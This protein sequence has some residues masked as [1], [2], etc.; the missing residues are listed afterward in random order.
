M[1][2]VDR[3]LLREIFFP[4]AVG[5]LAILQL[6]VILQ[7]LQLNQVVFGSAVTLVDLGRV[8]LALAPHFLVTAVPLAYMLGVQLG[9]GRLAGDQELLA[10]GAAGVHPLRLYRVPVAIGLVLAAGVFAL[11]RWAEPWGLQQ[12]NAVL[13]EVIKR[14][15]QSG[16]TPGVFNDALP[17]FTVYVGGEEKGAWKGVLIED[18][19]GDGAP[20]LALAESGRIEDVGGEA[21]ALR[22]YRGELHRNEP[23][24]ETV[25]RFAEGSFLVGVQ[26]PV[27]HQNRFNNNYG[28]LT[29]AQLRARILD[30]EREGNQ[31]E[32]AR[33]RVELARRWAAPLAV[34]FFALLAVP[35]AV[36]ARGA[37]GSAYLI[38]LGVFV[39]FYALSRLALAMAEGGLNAWL[40]GFLP[41]AAIGTL[42]IVYTRELVRRGVGKPR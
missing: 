37:R 24:G 13:N 28:Q 15:L 4:L 22:L 17:R 14:N 10:L 32:V 6:L 42:G 31:R 1:P 20:L 35:L 23:R 19:V 2:L 27:A 39:A 18:Q 8:T 3:L 11:A 12:L 26:D 25:A 41:D 36:V 7:L 40:A 30:I 5:L 33:L 38:T 21:L 29:D 16:L 34:V 9:L